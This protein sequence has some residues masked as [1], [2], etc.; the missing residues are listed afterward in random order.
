LLPLNIAVAIYTG[1]GRNVLYA[2]R[3]LDAFDQFASKP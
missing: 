1:T 3:A 2:A